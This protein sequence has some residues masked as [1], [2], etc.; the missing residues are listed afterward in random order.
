M[1]PFVSRRNVKLLNAKFL[2]EVLYF[3]KREAMKRL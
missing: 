3:C 2:S 1:V